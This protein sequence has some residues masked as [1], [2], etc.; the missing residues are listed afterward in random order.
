VIINDNNGQND[1]DTHN[2]NYLPDSAIYAEKACPNLIVTFL[3]CPSS[4]NLSYISFLHFPASFTFLY[5][6]MLSISPSKLSLFSYVT[7]SL[8]APLFWD[9]RLT[10]APPPMLIQNNVVQSERRTM[11]SF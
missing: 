8:T 5:L 3:C 7:P 4:L 2:H 10:L 6:Q 11:T 1:L 9:L